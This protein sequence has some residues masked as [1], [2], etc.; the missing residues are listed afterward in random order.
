MRK[1]LNCIAEKYR[2]R[3]MTEVSY[4][5]ISAVQQRGLFG[6]AAEKNKYRCQRCAE[7]IRLRSETH[8]I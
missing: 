7:N 6:F 4:L 2:E 5:E 1:T 8:G 3:K